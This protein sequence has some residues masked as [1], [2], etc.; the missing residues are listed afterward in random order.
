MAHKTFIS[1]KYSEAR[2][3]RDKIIQALGKD[4]SYYMLC[5]L[6]GYTMVN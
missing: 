4:A 3:L 6:T 1:Y 5:M 2:G